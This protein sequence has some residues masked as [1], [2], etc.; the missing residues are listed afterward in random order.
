MEHAS[1]AHGALLGVLSGCILFNIVRARSGR[2]L[3]IRKVP[4]VDHIEEAVGRATEMGRPML[5]S[6]GS[7]D[8]STLT[9][10]TLQ[11][12]AILTRVV[13]MAARRNTRLIVPVFGRDPALFPVTEELVREG[14]RS[15]GRPE[16]FNSEDL[17]FLSGDQFAYASAAIGIIE[18]E[19]V[20]SN[21]FFGYWEAESLLLAETGRRVGALQVAGTVS[22]EQIP[23]F[24][25]CCD[26]VII[27]E[28]FFA[29]SAYLTREPTL[30]GSL[31][32][33]DWAKLVLL[34]LVLLGWVTVTV[35]GAPRLL[36]N[37][38]GV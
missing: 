33:Q 4:G 6:C 34:A 11:A 29:V 3:F 16:L 2:E 21:F 30:L 17:P 15:A 19:R 7:G 23:F 1:L 25:C 38:L 31:V 13:S 35:A 27:G 24:L 9:V 28:E 32:G 20:A 36:W 22:V 14:Y 12:L 5:F 37:W 26:Y 18:R 8:Y 10:I